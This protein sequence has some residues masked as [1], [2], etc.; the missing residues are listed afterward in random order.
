MQHYTRQKAI[1]EIERYPSKK[2]YPCKR[3]KGEHDFIEKEVQ[4]FPWSKKLTK[5]QECQACGKR[6]W[7]WNA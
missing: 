3:R 4:L 6:K 1:D 2:R 5:I 7:L